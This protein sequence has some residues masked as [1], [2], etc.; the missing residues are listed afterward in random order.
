[1]RFSIHYFIVRL[2]ALFALGLLLQACG[3]PPPIKLKPDEI[4]WVDT[5]FLREIEDLKPELDSLCEMNFDERVAQAVDSIVKVR[6]LEEAK[7]RARI[8]KNVDE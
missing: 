8:P 1:M 5:L 7:L 3:E 6:K 4:R 2:F